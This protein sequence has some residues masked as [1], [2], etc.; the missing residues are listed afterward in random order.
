VS[1]THTI[2]SL[3]AKFGETYGAIDIRAVAVREGNSWM[4]AMAVIRVTYESVEVA[5]R[6]L[7][8]LESR[9]PLVRTSNLDIRSAVRPISEWPSLC[10]EI[11]SQGV[12]R[13]GSTEFTLAVRP[14]LSNSQGCLYVGNLGIRRFDGRNWP[15][16]L[17]TLS[18]PS[19]T[20]ALSQSQAHREAQIC[21]YADSFEAANQLCEVDVALGRNEGYYLSVC[22]PVFA[23]IS[24][25]NVKPD[26]KMVR[27]AVERHGALSELSAVVCVREETG[28]AGA[29]FR[30]QL[31]VSDFTTKGDG[32]IVRMSGSVS[33]GT[34]NPN[35]W[36]QT[37]L[38]YPGF[39]VIQRDENYVRML[40]PLAA[41]NILLESMLKLFCRGSRLEDLLVRAYDTKPAKLKASAAF[42]LHVAWFLGL[43]G[44]STIVLGEYEH[45]VA[46]NSG[47][48]RASVDVLAASQARSTLYIVACTLNPPKPEDFGNLRYAR[49]ILAREVFADS[50]VRVVP[51]LFT[52]ATGCPSHDNSGDATDSIPIIDADQFEFLLSCLREG[53]ED[54]FFQ[55]VENPILRISG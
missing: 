27:L 7:E 38:T 5:R 49:N 41:R 48:R 19:G 17:I 35:D 33:L 42:E 43:C 20:N 36:L 40:M 1:V 22:V 45:I 29:P 2:G 54:Q 25:I 47:V 52:S 37:R 39:G 8:A 24:N 53:R 31:P 18:M 28:V 11:I 46:P 15:C 30:E 51:V 16:L 23:A 14:D 50:G 12:L 10:S 9:H 55:F 13:M 34:V 4:N 3:I 44:L 6:R 21:G 32:Q 26:E